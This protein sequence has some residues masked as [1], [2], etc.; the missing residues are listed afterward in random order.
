MAGAA[1][2]P[3]LLALLGRLGLGSDLA[4]DPRWSAAPDFLGLI[5]DHALATAPQVIVECSS[6]ATTVLL[7]RCCQLN[8]RGR[9]WSLENGAEFA[10]R[11]RAQLT[12]LGLAGHAEVIDAPLVR[13]AVD[14]GE[15]HWYDLAG[16]PA[17][18][19]DMLVI[20]GPPGFLQRHSRL[21]ALP[22]LHDRLAPGASVFLDDAG[23]P[24][25]L[26]IVARWRTAYPDLAGEFVANER[27]CAVL[28]RGARR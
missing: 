5:V 6:G 15:F 11:T 2:P 28:H 17:L 22:R 4:Y 14:G 16:L 8:G 19:I 13:Q 9:V 24:D 10:A 25:E 12:R 7:A 21:P 23:R 18:A 26:E 3:A 27:G 20:D 1:L